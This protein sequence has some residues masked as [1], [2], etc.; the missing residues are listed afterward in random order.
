MLSKA[1]ELGGDKSLSRIAWQVYAVDGHGLY[2]AYTRGLCIS[3][4]AVSLVIIFINLTQIKE[5]YKWLFLAWVDLYQKSNLFVATG[6]I[7]S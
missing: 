2:S 7:S 1:L 3:V 5:T 4:A 6:V